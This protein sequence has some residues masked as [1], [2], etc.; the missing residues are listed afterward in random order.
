M[1]LRHPAQDLLADRARAGERDDRQPRVVHELLGPVVGHRQHREH[2]RRQVRLGEQRPQVERRQRRRRGRFDHDR[3][4]GRDRRTDLV[5]HQV[6][7]EV[8]RGDAEDRPSREAPHDRHAALGGRVRVEPLHFADEAPGLF[9]GPPERGDRAPHFDAR[10]R[11]RLARLGGDELG[12]GL[13]LFVEA[14][15]HVFEGFGPHMRRAAP[16]IRARLP[17]R[18]PRRPPPARRSPT[19]WRRPGTRR[20]GG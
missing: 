20:R 7:R 4:A 6:Q 10:P 17:R 13:G 19:R 14:P 5:R 8:E 2:R 12:A 3:A 1:L 11:D 9:G 16:R 15:A 18:R